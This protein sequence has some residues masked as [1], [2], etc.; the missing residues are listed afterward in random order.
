MKIIKIL[1]FFEKIL[2]FLIFEKEEKVEFLKCNLFLLSLDLNNYRTR[3]L[4]GIRFFL[5]RYD[6]GLRV[7]SCH[8]IKG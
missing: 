7:N 5:I 2:F 6:E 8:L 1:R 4:E 3:I